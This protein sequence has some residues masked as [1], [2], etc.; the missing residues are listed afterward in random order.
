MHPVVRGSISPL[1][2]TSERHLLQPRSGS[3]VSRLG[4]HLHGDLIAVERSGC[5]GIG[6][7]MNEEF[8]DLLLR[9]AIVQ[10][11]PQLSTERFVRAEDGGDRDGNERTAA[12]IQAGPRPGI[13]EG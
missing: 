6:L 7:D 9:H 8:D 10:G 5:T 4:E 1:P 3:L 2:A 13:A 12:R 11:D